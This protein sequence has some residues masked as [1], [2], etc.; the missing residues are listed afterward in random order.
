MDRRSRSAASRFIVSMAWAEEHQEWMPTDLVEL[1]RDGDVAVEDLVAPGV[2][3]PEG[4]AELDAAERGRWLR[5]NVAW[6]WLPR[7]AEYR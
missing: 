6:V 7:S 3:I 5:L 2:V 4:F 1:L